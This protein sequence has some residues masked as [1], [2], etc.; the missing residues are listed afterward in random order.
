VLFAKQHKT[1]CQGDAGEAAESLDALLAQAQTKTSFWPHLVHQLNATL[2]PTGIPSSKTK[3]M[4]KRLHDR[5]E[6]QLVKM[7]FRSIGVKL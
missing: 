3:K 2:I 7:P 6:Q 1:P 5:I 4:H